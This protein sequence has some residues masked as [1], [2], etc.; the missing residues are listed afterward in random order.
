VP[1]W[2]YPSC[3]NYLLFCSTCQVAFWMYPSC[4][5]YLLFCA[6]CKCLSERTHPV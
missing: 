1:F 5:N 2:T 4:S 6:K 3:L